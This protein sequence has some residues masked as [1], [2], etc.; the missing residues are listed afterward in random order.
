MA[1]TIMECWHMMSADN[2]T[3]RTIPPQMY[4]YMVGSPLSD[5]SHVFGQY[6]IDVWAA[7]NQK[8]RNDTGA[9]TQSLKDFRDNNL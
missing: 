6:N 1:K 3:A 8:I 5:V 7:Q 9:E 2:V 4:A